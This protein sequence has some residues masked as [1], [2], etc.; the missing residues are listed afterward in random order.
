MNTLQSSRDFE[1]Y[2]LGSSRIIRASTGMCDY[3]LTL[4]NPTNFAL[5]QACFP[6]LR[7]SI[8]SLQVV[9]CSHSQAV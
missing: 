5:P 4:L 8:L 9:A 6:E 7:I 1:L 3:Y 2:V